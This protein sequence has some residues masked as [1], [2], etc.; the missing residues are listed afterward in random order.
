MEALTRLLRGARQR[1]FSMSQIITKFKACLANN[2]QH[3]YF[4]HFTDA[5]NLESID[6]NGLLSKASMQQRN[7][8]PVAFGGNEWSHNADALKGL[9]DYVNLSFTRNHP[10]CH[11]AHKE[12]RIEKSRYI[13]ISPDVLDTAGLII[14]CDVV[15]KSDVTLYDIEEG[16]NHLDLEV[17]YTRTDWTDPAI[18][19][20]LRRAEKAELLVPKAVP[21]NLIV[22]V[23]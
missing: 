1:E 13:A 18:Q 21:P 7:I 16:I 17:L 2:S 12:G 19:E 4:Y 22:G 23:F 5:R 20:R 11:V 14:A 9:S 3:K 6:K 10:M 8:T 15:N